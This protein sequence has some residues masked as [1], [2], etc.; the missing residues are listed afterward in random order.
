MQQLRSLNIKS[1][2]AYDQPMPIWNIN[3]QMDFMESMEGGVDHQCL[4]FGGK[5]TTE[6]G[7]T[8][9]EPYI[10]DAIGSSLHWREI[11]YRISSQI[12][13]FGIIDGLFRLLFGST[14]HSTPFFIFCLVNE[15]LIQL[16]RLDTFSAQIFYKPQRKF[17]STHLRVEVDFMEE[18]AVVNEDGTRVP[19]RKTVGFDELQSCLLGTLT[20]YNDMINPKK[21]GARDILNDGREETTKLRNEYIFERNE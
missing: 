12:D 4:H 20:F 7:Q 8:T 6:R 9:S 13:R 1:V 14:C 10:L 15:T 11:Q 2:T 16:S 3:E 18:D 21:E 17:P 5:L 19:V